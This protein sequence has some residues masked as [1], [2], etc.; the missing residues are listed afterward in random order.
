MQTPIQI[1]TTIIRFPDMELATRDGH[2][3]RG[4]FGN[5]FH[6]YSPLLHNH[7]EDG[8]LR[9]SYPL[10]Q[11]KVCDSVPLLLGINEGGKMLTELFLRIKKIELNG[12]IHPILSKN[13]SMTNVPVGVS[14]SMH[15]YE[16]KTLWMA[17]NQ[18]NYEDFIDFDIEKKQEL[19]TRIL[20]GNILSFYKAIGYQAKDK[21]LVYPQLHERS[22]MFKNNRMLAFDG[23]FTANV[24]LPSYAGIGKS[25]SRGFG[26]I[27]DKTIGRNKFAK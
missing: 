17:L 7:F 2:K 3:L 24:F 9:Y 18:G 10:V 4:Y 21:I 13:I 6:A 25:V 22:T 8:R 15:K 14:K 11:Y 27:I 16:F 23:W 1:Q 12:K 19:L 20:I 26:T 5:L